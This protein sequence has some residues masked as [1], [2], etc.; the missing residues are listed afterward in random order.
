[1]AEKI[2]EIKSGV[3]RFTFKA[4]GFM[5]G[6]NLMI[7][8]KNYFANRKGITFLYLDDDQAN[9]LLKFLKKNLSGKNNDTKKKDKNDDK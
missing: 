2:K 1:M 6:H 9:D 7:Q 4:D 8:N 3:A 5:K